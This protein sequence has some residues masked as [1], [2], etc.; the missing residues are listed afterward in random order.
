M[1]PTTTEEKQSLAERIRLTDD[2]LDIFGADCRIFPP[3]VESKKKRQYT[4]ACLERARGYYQGVVL[5]YSQDFVPVRVP[6]RTFL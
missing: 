5:G 2:G 6:V 3:P 4:P 1:E